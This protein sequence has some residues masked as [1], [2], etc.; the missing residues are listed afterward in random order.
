MICLLF[1]FYLFFNLIPALSLS[2]SSKVGV[3]NS[4]VSRD[5]EDKYRSEGGQPGSV[6]QRPHL[7][8]G[9]ADSWLWPYGN[10]GL[11]LP[12]LPFFFKRSSKFGCFKCHVLKSFQILRS[13]KIKSCMIQ[14]KTPL[15]IGFEVWA[16]NF[17][18]LLKPYID[19]LLVKCLKLMHLSSLSY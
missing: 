10:V 14:V 12:S 13:I 18:L 16:P 15:W 19:N 1:I 11:S 2:D 7:S 4:D 3:T 6:D 5:G 9:A 17:L 8:S